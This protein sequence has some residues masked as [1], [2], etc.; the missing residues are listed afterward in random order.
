MKTPEELAKENL[1]IEAGWVIFRGIM[2]ENTHLSPHEEN[3]LRDAFYAGAQCF[4]EA[5]GGGH[6]GVACKELNLFFT[7]KT[8]EYKKTLS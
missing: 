5:S 2:W 1:Y 7:K 4:R 3:S 8:A 6:F